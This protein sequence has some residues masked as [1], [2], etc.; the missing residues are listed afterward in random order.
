[1]CAFMRPCLQFYLSNM[2]KL[3]HLTTAI[4]AVIKHQNQDIPHRIG[5]GYL[6]FG[7]SIIS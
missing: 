3:R 4:I 6:D 1:M 7:M 2:M 5:A